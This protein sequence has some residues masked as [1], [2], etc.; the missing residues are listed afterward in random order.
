MVKIPISSESEFED[1]RLLPQTS[2]SLIRRVFS[3]LKRERLGLSKTNRSYADLTSHEAEVTTVSF[4]SVVVQMP[5]PSNPSASPASKP[6][7]PCDS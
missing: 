6:E 1:C 5:H 2:S 7:T 4:G 3:R